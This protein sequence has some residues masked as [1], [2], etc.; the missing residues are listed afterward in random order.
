MVSKV[1]L[2]IRTVGGSGI[3]PVCWVGVPWWALCLQAHT[4]ENSTR[5]D[6][7]QTD[8]LNDQDRAVQKC[9][10]PCAPPPP[11]KKCFHKWTCFFVVVFWEIPRNAEAISDHFQNFN[12]V[13][14]PSCHTFSN[15]QRHSDWAC[16]IYVCD[17]LP[18]KSSDV[19]QLRPR[20]GGR[21]GEVAEVSHLGQLTQPQ[22]VN[23][24][25]RLQRTLWP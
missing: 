14:D 13:S 3:W 15:V 25:Q 20:L 11:K 4:Y 17:Q 10:D 2:G 23:G 1:E 18:V 12:C 6:R 24:S 9:A 5:A 19:T 7:K 16:S 21:L 8:D 22:R